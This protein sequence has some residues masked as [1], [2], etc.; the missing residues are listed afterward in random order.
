MAKNFHM[1]TKRNKNRSL[2]IR[3]SGDFDGSSACELINSLTKIAGK[4]TRVSIDTNGLRTVDT[5][6]LTVLRPEL[7]MGNNTGPAIEVT[8]RFRTVFQPE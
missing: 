7:H 6:G 8:G 4:N 5:F 1:L 2:S 3:L